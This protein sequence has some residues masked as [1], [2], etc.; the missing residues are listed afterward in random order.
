MKIQWL[1]GIL[2]SVVVGVLALVTDPCL[3]FTPPVKGEKLKPEDVIA[4]HIESIGTQKTLSDVKTRVIAGKALF[5]SKTIGA[6][7][8]QG[9][10][11][12]ASDGAMS[13]VG[14][15]FNT[16]EYSQE[17]VAYDGKNVTVG[18]IRPGTRSALGEFL[19]ARN[20]IFKE[21]L[22][23]GVLS[24]G[25][26]L[27]NLDSH[28]AR[29]EYSGTKKVNGKEAHVLKYEPKG[30]SDVQIRLYFDKNTFQHVQSEYEQLISAQMGASP[31]QSAS[32][33][34]SR[35]KLTEQFESF[36]GEQGL[37]LPHVYKIILLVDDQQSGR[38]LE[39]N[40]EFQ[41]FMYNEKLDPKS[42][43]ILNN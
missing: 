19:L 15:G 28:D 31:E 8:L 22:F 5:R 24:S 25:W 32:Q 27:L 3:A 37:V 26:A 33:R 18:Y 10:A 30:G 9:P 14:I 17:K 41:Q 12:I 35:I 42:F 40:L 13:L 4:K 7:Q 2:L 34:N 1:K 36:A 38:Q 11:V 43:N 21:G 20:V 23:G 39:W 16:A 29:I 6:T